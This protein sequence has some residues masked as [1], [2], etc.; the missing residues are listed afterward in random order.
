MVLRRG[1]V[2]QGKRKRSLCSVGRVLTMGVRHVRQQRLQR[3]RDVPGVRAVEVMRL[4]QHG[5]R[6]WLLRCS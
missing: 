3:V 1:Q 5:G 4:V 6:P 2:R